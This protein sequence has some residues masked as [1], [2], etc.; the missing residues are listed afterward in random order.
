M[1]SDMAGRSLSRPDRAVMT[2]SVRPRPK[3]AALPAEIVYEMPIFR[4]TGVV[5][6]RRNET[7]R[8]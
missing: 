4:R 2:A 7:E 6:R 5:G 1:E 8:V 3:G